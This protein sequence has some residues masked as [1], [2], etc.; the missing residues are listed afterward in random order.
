M[1]ECL[2]LAAVFGLWA[3]GCL[4]YDNFPSIINWLFERMK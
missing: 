3:I 1:N 2:A 4:V